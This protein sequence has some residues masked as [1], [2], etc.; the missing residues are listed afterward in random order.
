M[1]GVLGTLDKVEHD[2]A[3]DRYAFL[4]ERSGVLSF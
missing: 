4:G 1:T 3:A 2:V